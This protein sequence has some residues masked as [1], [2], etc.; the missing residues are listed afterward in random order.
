[1]VFVEGAAPSERVSVEIVQTNDRFQRARVLSVLSPSHDR[2]EPKCHHYGVCGGCSLQHVSADAQLR[3]KAAALTSALERIAKVSLDAVTFDPPWSGRPYGYRTRARF[4]I[5]NSGE[6]GLKRRHSHEV[7]ALDECPI[8]VPSLEAELRRLRGERHEG[9]ELELAAP[10]D[11]DGFG[12][13]LST[14]HV[15]AQ[16]NADGN[17]EMIRWV[18][19]RISGSSLQRALEL[20]SGSGNFTRILARHAGAVV[21]VESDPEAAGLAAKVK[22]D[23]V[24]LDASTA[25]A[26]LTGFLAR[27]ERF[28]LLLVDPPRVGL[29]PEMPEQLSR[30]GAERL[31][32]VS[33]DLGTFARDVGRLGQHGFRLE[34]ARLFDLYPQTPHAEVI[35]LLVRR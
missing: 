33:C 19:D 35:G 26:A 30:L 34:R 23:N 12:P 32:Y 22:P 9:E 14:P 1:V 28:S 5:G 18:G 15:F 4:A 11:D 17:T 10:L 24:V 31:I 6:L 8:L 2:V 3:S 7:V 25:E 13:L 29:S 16:A 27:E 21:A 20:Y